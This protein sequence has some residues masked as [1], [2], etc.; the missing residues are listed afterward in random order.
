MVKHM[1]IWTLKEE[2]SAEEK[3][4]IKAGV[5]E[6]L[7]SLVGQV[8]G[9]M[10]A[11]VHINGLPSSAGDMMLDSTF[12]SVESLKGY[13]NHPAHV[14]VANSKVRPYTGIRSCLDFEV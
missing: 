8:P 1:I 12:D 11:T 7:E 5:K 3:E 14:A 13:K 10:E 6:G 4:N 2:F 9:L